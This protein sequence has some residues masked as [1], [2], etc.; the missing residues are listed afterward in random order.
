MVLDVG[1]LECKFRWVEGMNE[2]EDLEEFVIT[3]DEY[4]FA[5][6][7]REQF[8]NEAIRLHEGFFVSDC[9]VRYSIVMFP[10]LNDVLVICSSFLT[11]WILLKQFFLELD[12]AEFR[13]MLRQQRETTK[14]DNKGRQQRETMTHHYDRHRKDNHTENTKCGIS[15]SQTFNIIPPLHFVFIFCCPSDNRCFPPHDSN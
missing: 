9:D 7:L 1:D 13:E 4:L 3:I 11:V 12:T 14:G 6:G 15:G 10:S 2:K 5:N 8:W